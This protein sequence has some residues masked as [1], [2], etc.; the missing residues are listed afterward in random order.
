MSVTIVLWRANEKGKINITNTTR[1]CLQ[2]LNQ[3]AESYLPASPVV[4]R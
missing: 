4:G 2:L 1:A 3:A